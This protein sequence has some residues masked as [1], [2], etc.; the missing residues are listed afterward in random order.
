[1]K[2]LLAFLTLI[3]ILV[4]LIPGVAMASGGV[5][6]GLTLQNWVVGPNQGGKN[7]TVEFYYSGGFST[8]LEVDIPFDSSWKKID[9]IEPIIEA[10]KEGYG[11]NL[12]SSGGILGTTINFAPNVLA[13]MKVQNFNPSQVG[14][15][16]IPPSS[17]TL[18]SDQI[19]WLQKI[20]Y[21]VQSTNQPAPT[22]ASTPTP[23]PEPAT[24]TQP[25]PQS[26]PTQKATSTQTNT[27]TVS[28]PTQQ[29]KVN[30]LP[31]VQS[32]P[33]VDKTVKTPSGPM[34][35]QMV[36]SDKQLTAENPPSINPT[37]IPTNVPIK[38][39]TSTT[40]NLW[41]WIA[42]VAIILVL[43]AVTGRVFYVRQRKV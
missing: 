1:M 42:V 11:P 6:A 31:T 19:T 36:A 17:T 27:P 35:P 8:G 41:I 37:N 18:T 25:Q 21:S 2:K 5:P 7:T 12:G 40:R 22:P 15:A 29:S 39:E 33:A 32:D 28:T 30:T 13:A 14:G 34:T 20:G 10:Y 4:C 38:K 16:N 26:Q 23:A 3:T 9:P 24:Q 43:G